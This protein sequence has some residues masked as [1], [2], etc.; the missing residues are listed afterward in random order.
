MQTT[1]IG[2]LILG[3]IFQAFDAAGN[4]PNPGEV[5]K[6]FPTTVFAIV[7]MLNT[8][9]GF[10]VPFLIGHILKWR[11]DYPLLETWSIVFYLAAVISFCG[12]VIFL[13]FGSAERQPFDFDV[14]RQQD[15]GETED[16]L[17][18]DDDDDD[19]VTNRLLQNSPV[20]RLNAS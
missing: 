10:I 14:G 17:S 9:A 20:R 15:E 1:V 16:L 13:L 6:N 2:L 12:G 3:S 4:I 18:D 19:D 8:S 11:A 7:N 5:S